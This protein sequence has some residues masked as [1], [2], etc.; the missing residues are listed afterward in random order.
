MNK[1]YP[2]RTISLFL[3]FATFAVNVYSQDM[4]A[5][6]ENDIKPNL[7]ISV[8]FDENNKAKYVKYSGQDETI[9]LFYLRREKNGSLGGHMVYWAETYTEKYRG[10]ITGTYTFTNAG[11]YGLDVTFKRKKDNRKFYFSIIE[12]SQD[13]DNSTFRSKPCF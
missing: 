10:I 1:I 2:M 13:S 8:Y 5:C 3:F 12:G 4:F 9:P 6:F 7:K 11:T